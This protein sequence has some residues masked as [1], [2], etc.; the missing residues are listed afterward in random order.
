MAEVLCGNLKFEIGSS[1]MTACFC[2]E[3]G[4]RLLE[5]SW[6]GGP[7]IVIPTEPH[8]FEATN[9]PRAGAYPLVPYHNRLANATIMTDG[10]TALLRSHPAAVP[11]TLHGPGHA[12]P[13]VAGAHDASRFS[14]HLDYRADDDWPWDFRAEQHFEIGEVGLHLTM[15]V[16]NRSDRMMPAGMGWHPYFASRE[17][18]ASD[19]RH[20][21][22][23][24][25]D[26]LP[27]GTCTTV[28]DGVVRIPTAYLS[29]WTKAEVLFSSGFSVTM[30][31]SS[32]F[33]FLVVHR[34]DPSHICVEPV[35]HVANAWN[36]PLPPS[37]TGA[38][39]LS[40]GEVLKGSI[41]LA[42]SG[43]SSG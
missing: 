43:P 15:S 38:V 12:H 13:W 32:T 20:L 37:Q 10:E 40:P 22:P 11:H 24:R 8:S 27:D 14:M 23:H 18:I 31:A 3:M 5:L 6:R 35:T 4:G 26:Y 29:S 42:V 21:W 36:L 34:G 2:P 1:Q 7:A 16:E 28:A 39:L 9:W 19:A 17:A 41:E 33:G 25:P 30:T